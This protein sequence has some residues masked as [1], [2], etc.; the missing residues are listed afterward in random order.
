MI[1]LRRL[2]AVAF[3]LLLALSVLPFGTTPT[4]AQDEETAYFVPET[5]QIIAE[6][7]LTAWFD[8]GAEERLGMPVTSADA[9]DGTT[10]QYFELGV[11][12]V[13]ED[14]VEMVAA[15][16]ELLDR[17]NPGHP[18][19]NDR[20]SP[21]PRATRAFTPLADAPSSETVAYDAGSRHAIKGAMRNAYDALGGADAL[22]AP[23]SEAFAEGALR[24]QWFELGR[25]EQRDDPVVLGPVGLQLAMLDGADMR[26][27]RQGSL[28]A[29]DLTA[30]RAG[31]GSGNL[32]GGV[33]DVPSAGPAFSP[34]RIAIPAIGIDASI[35]SIG[36]DG[37][38]MGV[39]SNPWNVGWYSGLG[40][41]GGNTVMAA[42]KDW[43]SIG[44]VVFYSLGTLGTGNEIYLY[45][46]DGNAATYIVYE[47][48]TV[49][50][51]ADAGSIIGDQGGDTLTL[52]TCGGDFSGGMYDL[53]VIV[54]ASR[55]A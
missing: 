24:V 19:R 12:Q 32:A 23:L 55:A 40:G 17:P 53:R 46:G 36:I 47:A 6:P 16:Q 52:I 42:H 44:P 4:V 49:G 7:L 39:P 2:F 5:R 26:P 13:T 34:A 9:S 51:Y 45:D 20:R 8:L 1:T 50:A 3:S 31:H 33:P 18:L 43:A 15:G 48:F 25:L 22:G 54:R 29:F 41:P 30:F 21:A 27:R 10:T 35:E 11:L 14:E 28:A 38:V 37:G